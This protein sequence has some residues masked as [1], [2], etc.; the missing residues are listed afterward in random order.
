MATAANRVLV[1]NGPNLNLLG[2]REPQVYGTA[3]L[4]NHMDAATSTAVELGL[5]LDNL[6]SNSSA[7]IVNAVHSARGVYDA[8]IINPGAFTHY[9]WSIHDALAAFSGP[10]VEVHLS[11]PSTREVWRHESVIAPVA[12]GTIAGFGGN[13]YVLAVQAVARLLASK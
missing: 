5:Q 6:Q 9:A 11:N 12:S 4:A 2:E 7:E 10:V 1:L 13:S 3:T 8:I